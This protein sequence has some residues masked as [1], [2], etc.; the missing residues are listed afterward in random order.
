MSRFSE[1]DLMYIVD[2]TGKRTHVIVPIKVYEKM[3]KRLKKLEKK[4]GKIK[5]RSTEE[6]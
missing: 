6:K 1:K 5:V 3:T 2:S 4:L